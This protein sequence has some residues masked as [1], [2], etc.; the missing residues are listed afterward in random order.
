MTTHGAE[1]SAAG[2]TKV[3]VIGSGQALFGF[4]SR[5]ETFRSFWSQFSPLESGLPAG[6]VKPI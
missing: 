2:A 4:D 6:S 1:P 5:F 3:A